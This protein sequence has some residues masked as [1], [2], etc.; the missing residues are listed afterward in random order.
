MKEWNWSTGEGPHL[1]FA[2]IRNDNNKIQYT[3]CIPNLLSFMNRPPN[4]ISTHLQSCFTMNL[5]SS[6][7]KFHS[8]SIIKLIHVYN[9]LVWVSNQNKTFKIITLFRCYLDCFLLWMFPSLIVFSATKY[10]PVS[11]PLAISGILNN[12]LK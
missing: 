4:Y 7:I 12:R 5:I 2:F 1:N 3:H 11:A 9:Y 8:D 6:L 10:I